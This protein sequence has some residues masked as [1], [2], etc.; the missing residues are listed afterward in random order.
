M[1]LVEADRVWAGKF[2]MHGGEFQIEVMTKVS[3]PEGVD[4]F[5]RFRLK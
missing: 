4:H 5:T 2:T 1:S 3:L